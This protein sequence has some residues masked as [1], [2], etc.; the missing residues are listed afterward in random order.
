LFYPAYGQFWQPG[1][2]YSDYLSG[3]YHAPIT[4]AVQEVV[5]MYDA[6]G[7]I[8]G[9]RPETFYYNAYWDPNAE[10]YGYYDYRG[11]FHW[12]TFPWLRSWEE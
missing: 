7:R 9:Y 6:Y 3:G 4:V 5:P 1:I 10:A 11:A 8:M 12:V 2:G